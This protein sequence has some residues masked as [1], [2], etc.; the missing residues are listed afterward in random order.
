MWGKKLG[1]LFVLPAN[2]VLS[3]LFFASSSGIVKRTNE[4]ATVI[5]V[6]F[7]FWDGLFNFSLF[8]CAI[9]ATLLPFYHCWPS[10]CSHIRQITASSC[11]TCRGH[12]KKPLKCNSAASVCVFL[13]YL[14]N[15][16]QFI[17]LCLLFG[18]LCFCSEVAGKRWKMEWG[19]G[20]KFSAFIQHRKQNIDHY[21]TPRNLDPWKNLQLYELP[22]WK[23]ISIHVLK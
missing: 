16:F 2:I 23:V 13:P 15:N 18:V 20:T 22:I 14:F 11:F 10:V 19:H 6:F 21:I 8:P 17:C 3:C 1:Y 9:N 4:T 5:F 12:K 7:F